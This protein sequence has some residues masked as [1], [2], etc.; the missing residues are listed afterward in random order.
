MTNPGTLSDPLPCGCMPVGTP[1]WREAGHTGRRCA[2]GLVFLD[3]PTTTPAVTPDRHYDGYYA[4]PAELRLD[5]IVRFCHSGRLLE[6]GP[7]A[8]HLLAAARRRGFEVAGVDPN[9]ASAARIRARLGI[10]IEQ[11]TIETSALPDGAFDVVVH[12]DLLAH[13]TDPLAALRAMA[14]RLRPGGHMCFEVGLNGAI[15]PGWYRA[16]GRLD[17]PVHRWLF[18]RAS[19][20]RILA[21]AGLTIVGTRRFG[22]VPA[23]GLVLA[24]RAA[25]RRAV[26]LAGHPHDP[27][28]LPAAQNA[29]H[30][31][32]DRAMCVLRY[33]VGRLA[34]DVG[35]QT[36]FVAARAS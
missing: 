18:S 27:D 33:R 29:A 11:A 19:V 25:G 4:Y 16:L 15:S 9:P 32:Y 36:L 10:D 12:I 7:G 6:V 5:W 34:P 20:E 35:P 23:L 3:P 30:R 22:L 28:G 21:R 14:R 26:Q 1:V 17:F 31:L 2:C 24:R 8:G 13:L